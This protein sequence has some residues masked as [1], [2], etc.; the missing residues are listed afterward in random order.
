MREIFVMDLPCNGIVMDSDQ[1]RIMPLQVRRSNLKEPRAQISM[2][3]P[4]KTLRFASKLKRIISEY[5]PLAL[6][7]IALELVI[8]FSFKSNDGLFLILPTLAIGTSVYMLDGR[9][10]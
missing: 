3:H 2:K 10:K 1:R 9:K 8:M 6:G 7:A 4:R 5:A